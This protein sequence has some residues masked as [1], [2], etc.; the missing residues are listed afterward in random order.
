M[1]LCGCVHVCVSV[2]MC[3]GSRD[4]CISVGVH[5]SGI[6]TCVSLQLCVCVGA[7]VCMSAWMYICVEAGIHA[8]VSVY[9]WVG[10]ELCVYCR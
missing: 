10:R 5:M 2:S 1:C 7:E 8:F 4:L 3:G 9:K 6:R